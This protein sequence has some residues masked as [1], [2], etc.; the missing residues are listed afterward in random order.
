VLLTKFG[1]R[2]VLVQNSQSNP[3][4]LPVRILLK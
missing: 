3:T 4:P 1:K 2:V